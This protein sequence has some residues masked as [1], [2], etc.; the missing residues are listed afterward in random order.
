MAETNTDEQTIRANGIDLAYETFGDPSDPAVVLVMGLG[1]Q[2][3][4]WPDELC[5]TIA[6][7]GHHVVRFD[8]RDIGR[9]THLDVPA[10]PLGQMLLRRHLPYR[11]E[12][13]AADTI[14]LVDALDIDRFHLVGASMGG[15][16]S[17]IVAIGH[18]ARVR[19][20]TLAMTSTGSRR[21][22]RPIPSVMRRLMTRPTA[23]T[24][25]AAIAEATET[26]RVIGSPNHIDL[27][28]VAE[29]AGRSY[30]RAYD[31]AGV[32]RQLAAVLAQSDRTAA[33]RRLAMP[34]LVVHGLADP[35]VTPSGGLAIAKAVPGATFVGH[36]GMAHDLPRTMW[37]E[38][39][40]D[41]VALAKRAG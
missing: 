3:I 32:Q 21:V 14:G 35:L 8:N 22:G 18:P 7:A 9:S 30:D 5:A 23:S 12:D 41:I 13:L 24:R 29:L 36:G 37:R 34:T 19:S 25:E 11:L 4:G 16:I 10:P 39:S 6:D 2:M 31:P 40:A 15:M 28:L 26:W 38:L 20:L 1:T 17:Q 33:L 27:D